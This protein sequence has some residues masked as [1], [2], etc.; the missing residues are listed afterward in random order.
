M[1][2]VLIRE[3]RGDRRYRHRQEGH[4]RTGTEVA[5]MLPLAKEHVEPSHAKGSRKD[6]PP[7][8]SE[9]PWCF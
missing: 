8:P 1:T 6:F 5:S 4:V 7:E 2:S 9:E 3:R